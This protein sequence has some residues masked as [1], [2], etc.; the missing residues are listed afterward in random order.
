MRKPSSETPIHVGRLRTEFE[1]ANILR[2]SP[3]TLQRWRWA[4]IGPP[5]IKV[6]RAVRYD[7]RD[8]ATFINDQRRQSRADTN[9][10]ARHE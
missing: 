4:G 6:G 3:K 1:A 7:E 10:G 2:M 8:L 5:Y 9:L